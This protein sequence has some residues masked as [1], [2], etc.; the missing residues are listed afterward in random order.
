MQNRSLIVSGYTDSINQGV[1]RVNYDASKDAFGAVELK[2]ATPNPSIGLQR[3]S[4]WYFVEETELGKIHIFDAENNWQKIMEVSSEGASPCFLALNTAA[5]HLAV[6]NYMGGNIAVFSLDQNGLPNTH[7]KIFQHH[8]Q[9]LTARQEAPH[10]HYVDFAVNAAGQTG[11]Y[12]VDLGLDQ[13]I[14]HPVIGRTRSAEIVYTGQPGDGPRHLAIHPTN[15]KFYVLNELTNTLCVNEFAQDGR[16][17]TRQRVC[18]L[19]DNF[20]GENSA[21]HIAISNNGQFIYT[22]NRGHNSIAVFK[23]NFEGLVDL[24]QAEPCGG[25]G[26][27]YFTLLN[28]QARLIVAH[29]HSNSLASFAIENDGKLRDTHARAAVHKPTFV[30]PE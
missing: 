23:I 28:E 16:W 11:V 24:I 12:A 7:P 26:P 13:I 3:G 4:L 27:R 30:A 5:N 20:R 2:V 22:S 10:A 8:G 17:V 15:G 29:E 18:T 19:P 6:A 25:I 14:W 9:G 1:C 21:A